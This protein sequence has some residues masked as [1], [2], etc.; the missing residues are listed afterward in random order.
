MLRRPLDARFSC[1]FSNGMTRMRSA[2]CDGGWAT[3]KLKRGTTE[4]GTRIGTGTGTG[5]HGLFC[6]GGTLTQ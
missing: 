2:D 5:T 4:R 3:E 1:G 6:S